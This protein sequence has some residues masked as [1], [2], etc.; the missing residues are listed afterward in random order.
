MSESLWAAG[1]HLTEHV[2]CIRY[3]VLVSSAQQ[4][5]M[6]TWKL[7]M[8]RDSAGHRGRVEDSVMCLLFTLHLAT[9]M[10]SATGDKHVAPVLGERRVQ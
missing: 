3:Y 7:R 5:Q 9:K 2:A 6:K 4:P 1:G 8:L 10:L